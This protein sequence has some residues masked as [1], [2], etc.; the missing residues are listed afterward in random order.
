MIDEGDDLPLLECVTIMTTGAQILPA[1][2]VIDSASERGLA[3]DERNVFIMFFHEV[4]GMYVVVLWS[5][6]CCGLLASP[7]S[8]K[9]VIY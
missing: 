1:V 5:S 9:R 7:V 3:H 2:D 8:L 4:V 6:P